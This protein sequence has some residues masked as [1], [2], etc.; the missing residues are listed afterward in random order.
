MTDE[1][2]AILEERV[3][4]LEKVFFTGLELLIGTA[5]E[6]LDDE[7]IEQL[8]RAYELVLS[9]DYESDEEFKKAVHERNRGL[10]EFREYVIENFNREGDFDR[11]HEEVRQEALEILLGVADVDGKEITRLY[12]DLQKLEDKNNVK[13]IRE[14]LSEVDPNSLVGNMAAAYKNRDLVDA[15]ADSTES[16]SYYSQL[17]TPFLEES[18]LANVLS[19]VGAVVTELY[20]GLCG[21]EINAFSSIIREV[22]NLSGSERCDI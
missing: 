15:I 17:C 20:V 12:R 9:K 7:R 4:Q 19:E 13:K 3:F 18:K 6:N 2:A 5:P 8:F 1:D 22:N 14:R 21:G 16:V 11:E 10:E